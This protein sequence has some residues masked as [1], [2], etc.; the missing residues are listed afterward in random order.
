M[1]QSSSLSPVFEIN[2]T[3]LRA[4]GFD[5]ERRI[6]SLSIN[7]STDSL[8]TITVVELLDGLDARRFETA[9]GALATTTRRY[10]LAPIEDE[11]RDVSALTIEES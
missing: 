8:P 2:R 5:E 11:P 7:L 10:V 3:I 4:L 9:L 6:V 1:S